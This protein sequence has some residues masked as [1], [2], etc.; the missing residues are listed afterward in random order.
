MVMRSRKDICMVFGN[1]GIG[2]RSKFLKERKRYKV[3]G[4]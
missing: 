3:Q 4:I 2:E 1:K